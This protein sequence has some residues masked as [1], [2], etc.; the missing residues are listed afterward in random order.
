MKH[1]RSMS[2]RGL[3]EEKEFYVKVS[4]LVDD[5]IKYIKDP[6]ASMGGDLLELM[7]TFSKLAGYLI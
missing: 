6:K 2:S 7:N 4:L 1:T 5:K 3:H